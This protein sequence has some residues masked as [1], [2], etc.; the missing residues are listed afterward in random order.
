MGPHPVVAAPDIVKS[1]GTDETAAA[2]TCRRRAAI[3]S[4]AST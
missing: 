1:Y 4:T 3:C 2:S